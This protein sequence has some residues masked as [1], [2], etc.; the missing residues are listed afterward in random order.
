MIS[1]QGRRI[2]R[3]LYP[4]GLLLILSPLLDLATAVWPLRAGEVSWRFG[5]FG[6]ITGALITPI[7]GLVLFQGAAT[8]LDHLKTLWT[9]SL[10]DLILGLLLLA[11]IA[12]F[13]LDAVQLRGA[14]AAAARRSY[15]AAAIKAL[16]TALLEVV[17]LG[18]VGIG[19]IRAVSAERKRI[20]ARESS[21][22][23]V[24]GRSSAS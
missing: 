14:V 3:G 2:L 17:V 8:L 10:I 9:V 15:D 4:V 7:L 24:V 21:A 16:L 12:L 6:L 1:S 11:G 5:T 18:W 23:L 19:G 13:A 20:G 22:Q